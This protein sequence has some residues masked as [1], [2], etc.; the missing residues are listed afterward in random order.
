VLCLYLLGTISEFT[1]VYSINIKLWLYT[2]YR[3]QTLNLVF[4]SFSTIFK[5]AKI[6]KGFKK[7]NNMLTCVFIEDSVYEIFDTY[8]RTTMNN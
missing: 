5:Q 3:D 8:L 6:S 1:F 2:S 4:V 7:Q